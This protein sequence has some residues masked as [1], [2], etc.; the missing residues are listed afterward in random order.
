AMSLAKPAQPPSQQEIQRKLSLHSAAK[1][2]IK[3]RTRIAFQTLSTAAPVSGTESD[4][5]SVFSPD[6]V[7][8]S[9]ISHTGIVGSSSQ[10]LQSIAE[11]RS[12]SGGEESEEDEEDEVGWRVENDDATDRGAVNESILKSGYLWKKG[13]RR[14]TWKKRWFVLRP[15][16]LAFYKTSA[17]YKLLRLLDVSDIHTCTPVSLKKHANTFGLVAPSRTFY[18]QAATQQDMQEWVKAITDA[19]NTL[20]ATSTQNSASAPIPIPNAANRKSL[21]GGPITASPASH[22]PMNYHLTSS[23]SED[24]S[25]SVPRSYPISATPEMASPSKQPQTP[26]GPLKDASKVILSG[27]LMKCGSRRH[28]WHNRWFILSGEKLMYCRS[29]MDTKPH[30]QI[31]LSQIID[32][33][34]FDL[35]SHRAG[36]GSLGTIGSPQNSSSHPQSQNALSPS[37]D[38]EAPRTTHTFKIITPKKSLLLCAPSEEEEIRWLSAVRALIARRSGAG[39]VPG[40]NS[41]TMA[42]ANLPPTSTQPPP[43]SSTTTSPGKRRDS[44]VR[45]LSLSGG[46]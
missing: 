20:A 40:D 35:P 34:E 16:Q 22:S 26:G 9:P 13:E 11:R 10:P 37:D 38:L 44:I 19:K 27:Y 6:I 8:P 7:P 17:E 33:L 1:P 32:A 14:K 43:S 41:T 29:H 36:P 46:G 39:V 21:A 45:R 30:R 3:V 31:P 25:P 12:A 2:I 28:T 15:S 4:S 42:N 18:L 24:A 23:E 5:D